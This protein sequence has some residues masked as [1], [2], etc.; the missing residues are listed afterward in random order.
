MSNSDDVIDGIFG[1]VLGTDEESLKETAKEQATKLSISLLPQVYYASAM[2]LLV[3]KGICTM[4]EADTYFATMQKK[5]L[6]ETKV[7]L[8]KIINNLKAK[9]DNESFFTKKD[10]KLRE[11]I[12]EE[13]DIIINR[14]GEKE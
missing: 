12:L 11:L 6:E 13:L 7:E 4:S 10:I 5:V 1:S 2:S 14:G 9:E 8:Q 3:D